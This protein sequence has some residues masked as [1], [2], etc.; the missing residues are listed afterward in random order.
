M[1]STLKR[2]LACLLSLTLLVTC[3]VSGLVLPVAAEPSLTE[4]AVANLITNG[5]FESGIAGWE[6]SA[7]KVK[8]G[9]GYGGSRG[10]EYD[11]HGYSNFATYTQAGGFDLDPNSVYR[12][13]Y[14]CY[15]APCACIAWIRRSM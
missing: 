3:A 12:I 2:T 5:D 13:T 14:R 7:S 9:I 11:T 1:K 10:L 15:G 8:D 4:G 6:A